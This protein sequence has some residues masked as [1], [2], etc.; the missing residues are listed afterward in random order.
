MADLSSLRAHIADLK[1]QLAISETALWLA[2]CDQRNIHVGDVVAAR[3]YRFMVTAIKFFENFTQLHG[4]KQRKDGG[5]MKGIM[6]IGTD[7]KKVEA[8]NE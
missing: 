2:E 5:F 6:W 7:W 1:K 4:N 3:G 8:G